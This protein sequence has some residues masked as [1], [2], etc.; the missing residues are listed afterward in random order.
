[1]HKHAAVAALAFLVLGSLWGCENDTSN[2][3]GDPDVVLTDKTCLGC[4]SSR[5][6]LIAS[7]GEE[8]MSKAEPAA[9]DDG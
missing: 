3:P 7:L 5:D 4:H 8:A 9:K 6:M 1:M 2:G